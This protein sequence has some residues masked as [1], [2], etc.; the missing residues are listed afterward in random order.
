MY[1][2]LLAIRKDVGLLS[3]EYDPKAGR[4]TATV[5]NLV[6][7]GGVITFV[8]LAGFVTVMLRRER[9]GAGRPPR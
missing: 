7:A 1:E 8:L 4:Y 5:R 3:E 6:R 2:R 9:A